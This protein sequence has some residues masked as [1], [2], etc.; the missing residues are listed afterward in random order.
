MST[1]GAHIRR[2]NDPRAMIT[3]LS[4]YD[5]LAHDNQGGPT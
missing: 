1:A 2:L 4:Q 5:Q 3:R